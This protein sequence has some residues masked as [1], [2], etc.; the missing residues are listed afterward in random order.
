MF[1]AAAQPQFH[2]QAHAP[3]G[4]A[5]E[6]FL[7]DAM[8]GARQASTRY[9]EDAAGFTLVMDMPG[10]AKDQLAVTVEGAVVRLQSRE[11]APR[12]YRAA[13]ELPADLDVSASEARLENGVLTLKLAKLAPAGKSAELVIQ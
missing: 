6:G 13:Y 3:A 2:L 9:T 1:F 12:Q 4:R 7:R 10:I 11:G 8:A 5:L